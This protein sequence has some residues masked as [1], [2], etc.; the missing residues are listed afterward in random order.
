[1]DVS[2]FEEIRDAREWL[3]KNT[4]MKRAFLEKLKDEDVLKLYNGMIEKDVKEIERR[5]ERDIQKNIENLTEAEVKEFKRSGR[6]PPRI[7]KSFSTSI[8]KV[9]RKRTKLEDIPETTMEELFGEDEVTDDEEKKDD[10][11][12][13]PPPMKRT[14]SSENL[15]EQEIIRGNIE[16]YRKTIDISPIRQIIKAQKE[17]AEI[18]DT[19]DSM[20]SQIEN[21]EFLRD[22]FQPPGYPYIT[23]ETKPDIFWVEPTEPTEL[24]EE[25]D[26]EQDNM[27][28]L[29]KAIYSNNP[30]SVLDTTGK[31]DRFKILKEE[32]NYMI[33]E[34]V[35]N[36]RAIIVVKGTDISDIK[37]QRKEDL[38]QDVGILLNNEDLVSRTKEID[39]V[40]KKLKES[41]YDGSIFITGHSL[42]GY[43]ANVVSRDNDIEGA[44]FNMGSS[45]F[46]RKGRQENDNITHYTTNVGTNI[47]PVSMTAARV[48]KFKTVQVQPDQDIGSGV[49]KYH[50]I[51]HFLNKSH[52]EKIK[53][54]D[55]NKIDM[56]E[57]LVRQYEDQI[58]YINDLEMGGKNKEFVDK[59]KAKARDL[60]KRINMKES[61]SDSSTSSKEALDG[62]V[63][64]YMSDTA[65]IRR[66]E[67][68]RGRTTARRKEEIS[69]LKENAD[70]LLT[71]INKLREGG[72]DEGRFGADLKEATRQSTRTEGDIS[73]YIFD[74]PP[75]SRSSSTSS[76]PPSAVDPLADNSIIGIN[77]NNSNLNE[78]QVR[79]MSRDR[80]PQIV[81]S[82]PIQVQDQI[83]EGP[84]ERMPASEA[85]NVL[86]RMS[87]IG[88]AGNNMS[89]MSQN[90]M[91]REANDVRRAQLRELG[92]EDYE[93][94]FK[95]DSLD[96]DAE[97]YDR[98]D[99]A[100]FEGGMS[101]AEAL[102]AQVRS[103]KFNSRG[104]RLDPRKSKDWRRIMRNRAQ[105]DDLLK[106][107]SVRNQADIPVVIQTRSR[108]G[109]NVN[110]IRRSNQTMTLAMGELLP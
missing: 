72:V 73:S 104:Q 33:V 57:D 25:K 62:M 31:G 61:R 29:N 89:S 47:D 105:F 1:M 88:I 71:R 5:L 55:N 27:A 11:L 13:P 45:P 2:K 23:R 34:D 46:G 14:K 84:E 99:E 20:L 77:S 80:D 76:I 30:Q 28:L 51:D 68:S 107:Q 21:K 81:P 60:M 59:E 92:G 58:K 65:Y 83:L 70:N 40:T 64:K 32:I 98:D 52:L 74:A 82:Q 63:Q 50:T 8:S 97:G 19:M 85:A 106:A 93:D 39:E 12:P 7:A 109:N 48:D 42:G 44:V 53:N 43:I 95:D 36:S 78:A 56:E 41:D 22:I 86:V 100:P 49:I 67:K 96:D 15:R 94:E 101:N 103:M 110:L 54:L 66:L 37:G 4:K 26:S 9:I 35:P 10:D 69:R 24:E 79:E 75:V 38:L 3:V 91:L 102:A 18:K 6:L 108:A 17:E 90:N 87:E 16:D